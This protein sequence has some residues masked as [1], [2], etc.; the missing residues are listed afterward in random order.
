MR[1]DVCHLV[2]MG[3]EVPLSSPPW[4]EA[5]EGQLSVSANA[6]TRP[7]AVFSRLKK[8]TF[9]N[10]KLTGRRRPKAGGNPTAQLLSGPC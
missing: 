9:R 7:K 10:V 2:T 4:A 5:A 3:Q 1:I 6:N 8:R